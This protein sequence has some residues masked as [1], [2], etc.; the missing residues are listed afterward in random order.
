MLR[1]LDFSAGGV[2][3]ENIRGGLDFQIFRSP[4]LSMLRGGPGGADPSVSA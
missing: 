1:N 3:L 2:F 4:V